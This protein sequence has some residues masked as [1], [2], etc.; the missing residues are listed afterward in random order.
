M[1]LCDYLCKCWHS[2]SVKRFLLL[3]CGLLNCKQTVLQ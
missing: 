1:Q 2:V 3:P